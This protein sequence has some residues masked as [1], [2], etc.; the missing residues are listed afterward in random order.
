MSAA[1]S[2]TTF[3]G[4]QL[5]PLHFWQLN[6]VKYGLLAEIATELL[7]IPSSTVSLERIFATSSPDVGVGDG[8]NAR[9]TFDPIA[10]LKTFDEPDKLERDA[11]LRFNRSFIP[12]Y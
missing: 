6:V 5:A 1:S 11:M 10:L 8:Y 3:S 9:I 2:L 4:R 7:T 12:K